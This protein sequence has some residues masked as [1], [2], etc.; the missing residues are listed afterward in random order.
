MSPS[1]LSTLRR[2]VLMLSV[3]LLPAVF[4]VIGIVSRRVSAPVS[5]LVRAAEEIGRGRPVEV[6]GGENEDELGR[7]AVGHRHDGQARLAPCRDA[8]P[9]APVLALGLSHDGRAGGS[10]PVRPGDRGRSRTPSGC[11]S[12]STTATRTASKPRL[13]AF[14]L[15]EELASQLK[16]SVDARSIVGMVFR[17]GEAYCTNELERDPYA[18]REL[19]RLLGAPRTPSVLR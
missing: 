1:S 15:T 3:L 6:P 17:T 18:S 10:G 5:Q 16:I 7:L 13:P 9:P 12:S 14:N 8:A 4:V 11:S 19:V 2:D